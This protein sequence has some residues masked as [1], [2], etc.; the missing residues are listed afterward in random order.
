MLARGLG[1]FVGSPVRRLWEVVLLRK[2]A[3][4]FGFLF[5]SLIASGTRRASRKL[6]LDWEESVGLEAPPATVARKLGAPLLETEGRRAD[7]GGSPLGVKDR[8]SW[9]VLLLFTGRG[10]GVFG[11]GG[12]GI[13]ENDC[14]EG[15]L[16][17]GG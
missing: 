5:V 9:D 6:T 15:L 16:W 7:P 8:I 11:S 14:L 3:I 2:A 12:S 13:L 17:G 1:A 10:L 4:F